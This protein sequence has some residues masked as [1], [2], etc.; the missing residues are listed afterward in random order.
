M[1]ARIQNQPFAFGS[2]LNP[3][4]VS[5]GCACDEEPVPSLIAV[6]DDVWAQAQML[7]C[8]V[9]GSTTGGL[10]TGG[11]EGWDDWVA[12][13]GWFIDGLGFYRYNGSISGNYSLSYD[14]VQAVAGDAYT[15]QITVSSVSG[16]VYVSYGDIEFE[17]TTD[18]AYEFN[19][20]AAENNSGLVITMPDG[21]G[22]TVESV[23]V[24]TL[25]IDVTA[26]FHHDGGDEVFDQ[27]A[28]PGIFNFINGTVT[29]H[30][31]LSAT[32][33]TEGCFTLELI[34]NCNDQ[35]ITSQTF[36]V[37]NNGLPDGDCDT[38]LIRACN[39]YDNIGFSVPFVPRIRI[40]ARMGWPVYS[41][42]VLEERD[43]TGKITRSFGDRTKTLT[44]KTGILNEW[45]HA[46]L[47]TLPIWDHVYIENQEVVVAN[48]KYEPLYGEG[49]WL[50]GAVTFDVSPKAELVRK[51]ACGPALEGC[52]P[53]ND[54]ICFTP[55]LVTSFNPG[56]SGMELWATMFNNL[57]FPPGAASVTIGGGAPVVQSFGTLPD[58][59]MWGPIPEGALVTFRLVNADDPSCIYTDVLTA[60]GFTPPCVAFANNAVSI[61][62]ADGTADIYA[63]TDSGYYAIEDALGVVT[64]YTSSEAAYDLL[65]GIYCVYPSDVDGLK[66][67]AFTT[68]QTEDGVTDVDTLGLTGGTYDTIGFGSHVPNINIHPCTITNYLYPGY[69]TVA[70]TVNLSSVS[71]LDSVIIE[72]CYG[73]TDVILPATHDITYLSLLGNALTEVDTIINSFNL[74]LAASIVINLSGGTSA[75]P[76]VASETQYDALILGGASITTN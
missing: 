7:P 28:Y 45:D 21:G 67:G 51:V 31:S 72:G 65:P 66:T 38:L 74:A 54:P 2:N 63:E 40:L 48:G 18:G 53:D 64:P 32:G 12:E 43:S 5:L 60:P 49:Q 9:G 69:S 44:I 71:G 13:D 68:L 22:V 73:L 15:I 57:N 41:T 33:I 50:N 75:A 36:K 8:S 76:T 23:I 46:F 19:V 37:V 30:M 4:T 3:R 6:G 70:Q 20:P 11:P 55:Q 29:L 52:A 42:E 61:V 59:L 14:L 26:I 10:F 39:D 62:V 27:S 34:S 1:I 58:T 16:T 35:S 56:D 47:S 24:S 25:D 17:I